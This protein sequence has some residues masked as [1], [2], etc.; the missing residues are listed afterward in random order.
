V[1]NAPGVLVT[2]DQC[3][4]G[5]VSKYNMNPV[6]KRTSFLTNCPAIETAFKDKY[7]DGSHGQHQSIQGSEGGERRSTFAAKYPDELCLTLARAVMKQWRDDGL[8]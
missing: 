8:A 6:H 7:C 1:K 5:A 2:F 4:F 3:M